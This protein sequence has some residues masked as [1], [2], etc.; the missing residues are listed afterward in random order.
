VNRFTV[1]YDACV[2]YPAPLRDLLMR[3]ALTDLYRARWSD[4]I[5]DEWITAVLRNRPERYPP[6]CFVYTGTH[7]ND[8]T[9]GWYRREQHAVR[10]APSSDGS[11]IQQVDN[12]HRRGNRSL[13][14]ESGCVLDERPD[15]ILYEKSPSCATLATTGGVSTP[16]RF[17][18][19]TPRRTS[20]RSCTR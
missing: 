19:R 17:R 12:L 4:E 11:E 20:T 15:K 10:V 2:L 6:N 9:V 13:C 5:H 1:V 16:Q 8:T 3:L 18:A 14:Y 7:D